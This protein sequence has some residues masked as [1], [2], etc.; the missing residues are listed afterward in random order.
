MN[1]KNFIGWITQYI[2]D[3]A[4]STYGKSGVYYVINPMI[5]FF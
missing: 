1:K 3:S 5:F 2:T 4:Y